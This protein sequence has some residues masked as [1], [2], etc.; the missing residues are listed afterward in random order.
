MFSSL[1]GKNFKGTALSRDNYLETEVRTLP[2]T[3]AA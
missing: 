3:S 1:E 2:V